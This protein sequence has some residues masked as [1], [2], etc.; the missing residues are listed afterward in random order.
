MTA[1]GEA[2]VCG[3][4]LFAFECGEPHP[5]AEDFASGTEGAEWAANFDSNA[6][7]D[8]GIAVFSW[9][10]CDACGSHLGGSRHRYMMFEV[11]S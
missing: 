6:E 7:E 4:C 2:W 9:S 8:S 10:A 3:D 5:R 1:I 11:A